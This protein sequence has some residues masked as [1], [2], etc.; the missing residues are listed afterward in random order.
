MEQDSSPKP[1][2]GTDSEHVDEQV[3][4]DLFTLMTEESPEGLVQVLRVFEAGVPTRLDDAEK[5]LAEGR[6]DDVRRAAHN[7][8]GT[9]GA[10]GARR[11]STLCD[12][13]EQ[14]CGQGDVSSGRAL[15]AEMRAEFALF[16]ELLAS[17][18]THHTSE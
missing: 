10:F 7:L 5:A 16:Q 1:T 9:A 18:L 8:R 15:V 3:L 4:A 17:R 13:L 12:R 6:V 11:L 14:V 2:E